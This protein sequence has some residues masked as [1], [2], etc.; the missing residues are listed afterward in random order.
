M[1]E[2]ALNAGANNFIGKTALI[3]SLVSRLR[4][5]IRKCKQSLNE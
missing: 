5:R 3:P 4:A 1:G 2:I